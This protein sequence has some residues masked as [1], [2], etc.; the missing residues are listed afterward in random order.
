M[1]LD[2]TN[3][4]PCDVG[5]AEWLAL[6]MGH[7]NPHPSA[8]VL[9][10]HPA[11]PRLPAHEQSCCRSENQTKTGIGADLEKEFRRFET[12]HGLN[13]LE[14]QA[15]SAVEGEDVARTHN[16]FDGPR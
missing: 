8:D 10:G 13:R 1:N 11:R 2:C 9:G 5:G 6:V 7:R 15:G 12:P 4:I 16:R 3:D 14:S